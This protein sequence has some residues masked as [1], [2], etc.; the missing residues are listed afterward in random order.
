MKRFE[1]LRKRSIVDVAKYLCREMDVC[2]EDCPFESRC[3][4][5]HGGNNGF[6]NYL[7]EEVDENGNVVQSDR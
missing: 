4:A 2:F 7:N 5:E 3:R 1:F 6:F